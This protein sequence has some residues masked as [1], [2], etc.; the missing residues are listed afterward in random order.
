MKYFYTLLVILSLTVLPIYMISLWM[1]RDKFSIGDCVK[2]IYDYEFY[3]VVSYHKIIKVGKKV[4]L[5]AI[6]YPD[7]DE[8]YKGVEFKSELHR[9]ST[10]DKEHCE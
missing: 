9:Y 2:V 8:F 5:T 10:T 1:Q 4:Y 3:E 7:R 6:K